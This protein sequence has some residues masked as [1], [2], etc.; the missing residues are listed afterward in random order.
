MNR[1]EEQ[2]SGTINI[3]EYFTLIELLVVIAIIAILAA[4]LMPALQQARDRAKTINC[5][6]N[7]RQILT[8]YSFYTQA[9][10]GWC[11]ATNCNWTTLGGTWAQKLIDAGYLNFNV[12]RCAGAVFAP[13]Y[14]PA[15]DNVGIGLNYQ[16][17][18]L[19]AVEMV[20]EAAVTNFGRNSRLIAFTDVP[21]RHPDYPNSKGRIFARKQGFFEDNPQGAHT[22]TLRHAARANAEFFDGH[23]ALKDRHEMDA[24]ADPGC[25]FNPMLKDGR[26][27]VR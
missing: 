9:N 27:I 4:M 23:T 25:L 22:I 7:T 21:T 15:T 2:K 12:L 3:T 11:L 18:G 20:K 14:P 16:T 1:I 13:S 24:Q 6:A 8:A 19:E 26:L 10:D 5:A 17:F